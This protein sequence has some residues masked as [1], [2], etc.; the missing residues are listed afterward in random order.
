MRIG[1]T[2]VI[3]KI[4]VAVAGALAVSSGCAHGPIMT[5]K[6]QQ[7]APLMQARS[8]GLASRMPDSQVVPV[9]VGQ[10]NNGDPVVRLAAHEE[11]R[12]RTGQ[13]FG[14]VPWAALEERSA[15]A[16]RWQAWATQGP[17]VTAQAPR[18]RISPASPG[19]SLPGEAA[20]VPTSWQTRAEG[21]PASDGRARL[22][23]SEVLA[24]ESGS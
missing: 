14:Y 4:G 5:R 3:L 6:M 1:Q 16:E 12:R 22:P 23:E 9:L 15:A 19:K 10:L 18:S 24:R 13:D 17:L 8:I 7:G 21:R 2:I 11:L 20:I